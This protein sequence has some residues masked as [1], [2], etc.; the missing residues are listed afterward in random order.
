MERRT[1]WSSSNNLRVTL[2]AS[3][4]ANRVTSRWLAF[5]PVVAVA[6]FS[7]FV[8]L[9][10]EFEIHARFDFALV[11]R[12]FRF[13]LCRDFFPCWRLVD[14]IANVIVRFMPQKG[15][16]KIRKQHG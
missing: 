1:N 15:E 12:L 10:N 5:R 7:A 14:S 16:E 11:R 8:A 9:N 13:Q 4:R 3:A 6:N 2:G